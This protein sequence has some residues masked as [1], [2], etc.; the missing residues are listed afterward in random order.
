MNMN[1]SLHRVDRVLV[2]VLLTI[3]KKMFVV[4]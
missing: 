4:Q 1:L 2:E 3:S